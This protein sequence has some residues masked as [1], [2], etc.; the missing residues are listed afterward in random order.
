M[1]VIPS[2][3]SEFYPTL[4]KVMN[5]VR[6]T[7]NDSF[8]GATNTPGEGQIITDNSIIS[9]FTL[10]ILNSAIREIYRKLRIS[11]V[12]TLIQDNYIL[13]SLNVV[14]GPLGEGV[15]DPAIQVRLGFDGYDDGSGTVDASQTLPDDLIMP[16]RMWERESN[17]N[18]SFHPMKEAAD[19]LA[20]RLQVQILGDWEWRADNIYMNG[21]TMTRDIRIRYLQHMPE[22]FNPNMDFSTVQIP[23]FD[24][25]DAVALCVVKKLLPTFGA[26]ELAATQINQQC[27]DAIEDLRNEQIKRM[28]RVNYRRR[29][30][31]D[32]NGNSGFPYVM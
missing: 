31:S 4:E 17:T 13:L 23:V 12:P 22:F 15:P 16:L 26:S 27:A 9:P 8:A 29:A 14:D 21:S 18:N 30:Y 6:A 19:G 5:L 11:G 28:Q 2:T 7:M 20:G 3:T 32:E 24:C 10:P 1:P 25:D